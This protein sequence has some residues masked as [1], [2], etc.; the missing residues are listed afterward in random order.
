M[1]S[2]KAT[3][4]IDGLVETSTKGTI[5][6]IKDISME[7]CTGTTEVSTRANGAMGCNMVMGK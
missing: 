7:R 1:M 3:A 5:K 2:K 6:M 4:N